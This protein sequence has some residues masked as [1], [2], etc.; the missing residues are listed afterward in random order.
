MCTRLV[1]LGHLSVLLSY[2]IVIYIRAGSSLDFIRYLLNLLY[3]LL[4]LRLDDVGFAWCLAGYIWIVWGLEGLLLSAIG[5][6]P[7]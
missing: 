5:R 1:L 2:D 7:H 3:V 6:T 4:G